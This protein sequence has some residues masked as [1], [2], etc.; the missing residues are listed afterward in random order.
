MRL[1]P[2]PWSALNRA[3]AVGMADGPLAGLRALAELEGDPKLAAYHL[4]PAARADLLARAGRTAEAVGRSTRP[5]L[6]PPP[7][8]S[9]GS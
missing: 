6:W 5:S 4:L 9:A 7:T 8:R 1:T 2:S 3:I